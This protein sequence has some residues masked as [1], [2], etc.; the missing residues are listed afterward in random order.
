MNAFESVQMKKVESRK[1]STFLKSNHKP[2]PQF[3][4]GKTKTKIQVKGLWLHP[5]L[6]QQHLGLIFWVWWPELGTGSV[7]GGYVKDIRVLS[8]VMFL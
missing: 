4:L 3:L 6:L 1:E 2:S 8:R 7:Q 5:G